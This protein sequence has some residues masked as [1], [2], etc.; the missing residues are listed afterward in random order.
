MSEET[1]MLL[2]EAMNHIDDDLKKIV[3][4]LVLLILGKIAKTLAEWSS[5]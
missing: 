3:F 1:T 4:V 2:I 5:E